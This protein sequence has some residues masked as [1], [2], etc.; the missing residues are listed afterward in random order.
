MT[1]TI[2]YKDRFIIVDVEGESVVIDIA[3]PVDEFDAFLPKAQ[4]VLNTVEWL[5]SK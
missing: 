3:A 2:D 1:S 5:E 4:K